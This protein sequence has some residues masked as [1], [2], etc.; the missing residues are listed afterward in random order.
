MQPSAVSDKSGMLV[1]NKGARSLEE[2]S[3]GYV[4]SE[5]FWRMKVENVPVDQLFFHRFFAGRLSGKG[6]G[7]KGGNSQEEG[8][9][10]ADGKESEAEDEVSEVEE[11]SEEESVVE[12]EDEGD[13]DGS[14]SDPEEAEI[15]KV[16]RSFL[17]NLN[18]LLTF[19]LRP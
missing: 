8:G 12:D 15:W 18:R 9:S 6:K 11:E 16:S 1:N 4:N 5:S 14:E 13:D 10:D 7:K 19:T 2:G 17:R 3:G